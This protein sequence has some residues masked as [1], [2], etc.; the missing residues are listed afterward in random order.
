MASLNLAGKTSGYVK[1]TA[2][3][4]SSTN[5]TVVL[6]SESGELALKSDITGGGGGGGDYTPEKMVWEDVKAERE[7]DKVYTNNNDVPLYVQISFNYDQ[8]V[9]AFKIDGEVVANVGDSQT[10]SIG[11]YSASLFIVPSKSNYEL[12][13]NSGTPIINVWKEAKM[14]VAVGTGGKT[15]AFRGELSANQSVSNS[16]WTK[17]NLDEASIDTDSAFTDGKFQPSVAG[18]YQINGSVGSQNPPLATQTIGAVYKNGVE[19]VLSNH[20]NSDTGS[21]RCSINDVIYLNG[22]TDYLELYG[23]VQ[24]SSDGVIQG[25]SGSNV[26]LTY[27]SAVLVSGGSAS[28]D[29][30]WT[31]EDGKAVYDGDIKVNQVTTGQGN[32][33]NV[34][35]T[36]LGINALSNDVG[37]GA[38]DAHGSN[39]AIGDRSMQDLTTGYFNT[40]IGTAS[41]QKAVDGYNNT[42]VGRSSLNYCTSGF[43]NIG[44]GREA[45]FG[46]ESRPNTGNSNVGIGT[47]AIH[48]C[49]TGE[50]NVGIG[51]SALHFLQSGNE[52]VA[53]GYGAGNNLETGNNNILIGF[54]VDTEAVD[55]QNQTVIGNKDTVNALLRG[56]LT[57]KSHLDT[58]SLTTNANG[59]V[60]FPETPSLSTTTQTGNVHM[61]DTGALYLSTASTYTVEEVDKKL[62]VKDKLIEK[63]SARLDELEKKLKK[64]K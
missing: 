43:D 28:G 48:D 62:A 11:N 7:L 25:L 42:A 61:T 24:A 9:S 10:G 37:T 63:L 21:L 27:L 17:V 45:L 32:N 47:S 6:P 46:D 54:G 38:V 26:A 3:D 41:L 36:A 60:S 4:D 34:K 19:T 30:I 59:R 13:I 29:S 57:V 39:T 56:G 44:I 52:N 53:I 58:V 8:S 31:E 18:Y 16:V 40:A 22:S 2:P 55:S 20:V 5:P 1:V 49:S 64:A 15:V 14:P 35:N 12:H 23:R 50:K 51:R 33:K